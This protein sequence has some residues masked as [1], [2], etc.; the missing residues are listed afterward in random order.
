MKLNRF[1]TISALAA[2]GCLFASATDVSELRIY[3]NPGH[4]SWTGG[5]RAMETIKHGPYNSANPDT[6]GFF[7]SNTNLR[8]GF[9]LVDRLIQYGLTFD[10]TKNQDNPNPARRGA[11]LD[12][13]NNVVMSHV[14][15]GPYPVTDTEHGDDYNRSLYEIACEVERNNFDFFIS[16]HSNAHADG[17]NTNYPALFVRGENATASVAGSDDA[18][19]TIWPH[20]YADQH[21]C[22]SNY[23]MSNVAL[24][25]D[26]DFW[27]GDYAINNIDGKTYKGYYGVLRHGVKGLLCEGYFHTYQPGR[28]RAMNFDVCRHE[29]ELYAHGIAEIFGLQ[30]EST[31]EIYGIIRDQH[32]RFKHKVYNCSATSPDAYKPINNAHVTLFRD[33]AQVAEYQTDDEYNGAFVFTD[34]EPG[35]Y[36]IAVKAEGYKDAVEDYCGPF[37]VEAAKTV[38]PRV[39]M[40]SESYE[41]PAI[42]YYDYPDEAAENTSIFAAPAY[43]FKRTFTDKKIPALEG[44]TVKRFIVRDKYLYVLAYDAENVPTVAVIDAGNLALKANVSLTG[45]EGTDRNVAD[46]QVTADGVLI[47]CSMELCHLTDGEVEDGET[48]GECKIYRWTND[49]NGIPTGDPRVWFST[50]MTGNLYRAWTGQTMS[51]SGTFQEGRLLLSSASTYY[52]RKVFFTIIDV[53]EGAKASESFSNKAEVCDYFNVDDLEEFTFTVSP[54]NSGSFITE[55]SKLGARQYTIADMHL[56]GEVPADLVPA[57]S[58]QAGYMRFA[59]HS[60]MISP[61]LDA[62]GRNTG[63]RLLDITD[64]LD[65]A[66]LIETENTTLDALEG[67]GA[68]CG[69]TEV[70]RDIEE[71]VTDAYINLYLLR[72]GRITR[73][74]TKG[75]EQPVAVPAY[76]Y[77]LIYYAD[78]TGCHAS[79]DMS[80]EGTGYVRLRSLTEGVADFCLPAQTFA[81]GENIVDI[82]PAAVPAGDYKVEVVVENKTVAGVKELFRDD[83]S[84][85]GVT[86]DDN[87]VSP[88][89]GQVY[90]TLKEGDRGVKVYD[91][92]LNSRNETPYLAGMW[93][94]SV[95]ASCWRAATLEDGT[96]MIADWGDKAGGIYLMDPAHP[97]TRT[98]LFK[99]TQNTASGEITNE[100]GQVI[101]GST[102]GMWALGSGENQ[103]LYSFQE[104]YPSDYTLSMVSYNIG[105]AHEITTVPD[106]TYPTLASMMV[107]G[108]VNV[109]AKPQALFLSQTRGS[110]NNA[111]AVPVFLIADYEENILFNSGADL[112]SLTGGD[113]ALAVNHDASLMAFTDVSENVHVMKLTWAPAFKCEELYSFSLGTTADTYQMAFDRAGR[114][115]VA[116]RAFNAVYAIP[117][118]AS[119]AVTTSDWT[120]RGT[121]GVDNVLVGDDSDAPVEYFN[122]QGIRVGSEN[123]TPGIYIRRQG[124]QAIKVLVK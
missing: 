5:D 38:Y 120:L 61:A 118:N 24:Y 34:L 84:G 117:Q 98:P 96:L 20:A 73:F 12:L 62:E 114:L 10:R 85:N 100:A 33:G 9:G 57:A 44:K 8:K 53:L 35:T 45:C 74:T 51:Y 39:Y 60:F 94:L 72:S 87:E 23:S 112:E 91:P 42:Q 14:K 81:A 99:G 49:D 18:C 11:A 68:A 90:F 3:V 21:Q 65:K 95:G 30:T 56:E 17:N 63:I 108:N 107:N 88:Y 97:E 113:G 93:D 75:V 37:T 15:C 122:L 25:F 76:A 1:L 66:T 111:K 116:N 50:Q 102:P 6:T 31:G 40:E 83:I 7:E 4:G 101:A 29:G 27:G 48:R 2:A 110:G 28:H 58:Q 54:L 92:Q 13:T 86:V 119:Q 77:N 78:N 32:E 41:P 59:G 69:R 46:I 22:W 115:Y 43:S 124:S 80:G 64:G 121:S 109:V 26:V 70:V 52:N 71:N 36:T 19:R 16:V 89:F 103:V 47:A 79:F 105:T 82:D 55:S 104:D 67:I 106:K 123:L